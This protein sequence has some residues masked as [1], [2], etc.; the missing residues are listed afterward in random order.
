MAEPST[1]TVAA[2]GIASAGLLGWA[3]KW[4]LGREVKRIDGELERIDG[5]NSR[6]G[7]AEKLLAVHGEMFKG[8][9]KLE[10]K[11]DAYHKDTTDRIDSL[12]TALPKRRA[13]RKR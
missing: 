4:L 13:D 1:T 6:M 8:V 9:A 10:G 3:F 7:E 5:L 2:G 11:L 12:V